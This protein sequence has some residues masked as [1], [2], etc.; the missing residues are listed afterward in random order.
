MHPINPPHSTNILHYLSTLPAT[1]ERRHDEP[2][3]RSRDAI[4]PCHRYHNTTIHPLVPHTCNNS[5][6]LYIQFSLTTTTF[7]QCYLITTNYYNCYKQKIT[8][9]NT[10]AITTATTTTTSS[11][12]S[13]RG[14]APRSQ[15]FH[16]QLNRQNR[17]NGV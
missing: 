2:D 15:Q 1:A 9:N 16:R 5:H 13:F 7:Y 11:R 12:G 8:N 14:K 3:T 6:T 10:T 17:P 4:G